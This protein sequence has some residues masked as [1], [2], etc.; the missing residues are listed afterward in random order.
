MHGPGFCRHGIEE[1]MLS[2]SEL[3]IYS[4][5]IKQSNMFL[6]VRLKAISLFHGHSPSSCTQGISRQCQ[7]LPA[8]SLPR[9]GRPII[10]TRFSRASLGLCAHG[11]RHALSL[12]SGSARFR[13]RDHSQLFSVFPAWAGRVF[14]ASYDRSR[15][16][17]CIRTLSNSI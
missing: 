5:S 15:P 14:M 8:P 16:C 9:T 11:S 12:E 13:A 1:G 7:P 17:E 4:Q 3:E 2:P 10:R 6:S